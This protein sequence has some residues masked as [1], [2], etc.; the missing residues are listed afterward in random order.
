MFSEHYICIT[1]KPSSIPLTSAT[2]TVST[3]DETQLPIKFKRAMLDETEI[4][5]I[6]VSILKEST[7][8]L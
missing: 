8:K 2:G 7:F 6:N 3:M 1:D 4:N 5:A